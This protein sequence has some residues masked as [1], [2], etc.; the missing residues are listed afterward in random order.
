MIREKR[1]NRNY[2]LSIVVAIGGDGVIG[3]GD[4]LPW[5]LPADMKHFMELTMGHTI[6]MGRK[7][8]E[9]IGVVLPGR[10]N[11]ILTRNS[12]FSAPGCLVAHSIPEAL[13]L[14]IG[15]AYPNIR[16]HDEIFVIGGSEIYH[17]FLS[18]VDTLYITHIDGDF[19]GDFHF[20]NIDWSGWE[21]VSREQ[22]EN[23]PVN[24]FD[25][26]FVQYRRLD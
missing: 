1:M 19:K 6:I 3:T 15:P 21:E 16:G 7:T 26:Q 22:G 24:P 12:N 14:A 2:T 25:H 20:P 8:H 9:S 18:Q 23:N 17:Q 10:T 11:I 5:D 13:E 4:R